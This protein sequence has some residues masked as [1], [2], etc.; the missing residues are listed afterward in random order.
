MLRPLVSA[1]LLA[2]FVPLALA[3][4]GLPSRLCFTAQG[5]SPVASV[6]T[7][8]TKSTVTFEVRAS[9]KQ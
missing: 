7:V 6:Q 3:S 4:N 2:G 9:W 1:A 8:T 5:M